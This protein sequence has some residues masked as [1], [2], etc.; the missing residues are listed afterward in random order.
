MGWDEMIPHHSPEPVSLWVKSE[1]NS[2]RFLPGKGWKGWVEAWEF[3]ASLV[4][5]IRLESCNLHGMGIPEKSVYRHFLQLVVYPKQKSL[6]NEAIITVDGSIIR[7]ENHLG[8]M[9]PCK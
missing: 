6:G 4:N 8:C 5:A 7:R 9:N 1:G 2:F 3:G